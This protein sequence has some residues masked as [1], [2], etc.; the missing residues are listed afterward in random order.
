MKIK[1]VWAKNFKG[2]TFVTHLS[3]VTLLVG[4]NFAGKTAR[5]DAIRL[6]LV[7][8]LPELG[9][10]NLA[11]FGLASGRVME[12]G[13]VCLNG[14]RICRR[15]YAKGDS[16]KTEQELPPGWNEEIER[17]QAMMLNAEEYFA[18]SERGRIEYVFAHCPISGDDYGPIAVSGRMAKRL[19]ATFDPELAHKFIAEFEHTLSEDRDPRAFV[20][21]GI[22]LAAALSKEAKQF[23]DRME[24][25]AQGLGYLRTQDAPEGNESALNL[26][27]VRL[28]DSI[29]TLS[30]ARANLNAILSTSKVN[31]DRRAKLGLVI[32]TK[33]AQIERK[34]AVEARIAACGQRLD[35]L[36]RATSDGVE[37]LRLEERDGAQGAQTA[38]RDLLDVQ[39]SAATLRGQL[40]AL[41]S[42]NCCPT[43]GADGTNWRDKQRGEI[44][45]AIRGLEAKATALSDHLKNVEEWSARKLEEY[46]AAKLAF[47]TERQLKTDGDA[48]RRDLVSLEQALASIADA[49]EELAAIP[50]DDATIGAEFNVASEALTATREQLRTVEAK[51]RLLAGRA[52]DLKRLAEAELERDK[53]KKDAEIAKAASEVL[54]EIQAE[55]VAKA[56]GSLLVEANSFFGSILR[57]PIEY[58]DGEIGTVRDGAWV[59][60]R[61][62]SGTE[63]ALVYAAVQA[64]LA[65][66]AEF[67]IMMI[68]ELARLDVVN[69]STLF[70]AITDAINEKR[71]DQFVGIVPVSDFLELGDGTS[72]VVNVDEEASI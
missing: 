68:D 31:A 57:T 55:M 49:E 43:C 11:T 36:A 30:T 5:T 48:L 12:V 51:L 38:R 14:E 35:G 34:V 46:N 50:M 13:V 26:E 42:F 71:L 39:K 54:R 24:K 44:E 4:S 18:L 27:H 16:I 56:V 61:T 64:A 67:R 3:D 17:L 9:K 10:Q 33:A 65:S 66:K 47:N 6:A 62:F 23:A 1:T 25:T 63:K 7:G 20:E 21:T 72:S 40:S 15:W 60:H 41:E 22:E 28:S 37:A 2:L 8:Y 53:A 59:G 29:E 58:R 19:E 45:T 70:A 32:R 69:R 52:G